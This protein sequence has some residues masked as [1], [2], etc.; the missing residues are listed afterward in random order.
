MNSFMNSTDFVYDGDGHLFDFVKCGSYTSR[1]KVIL[2]GI[3]FVRT[4][5]CTQ[6][7]LAIALYHPTFVKDG[8]RSQPHSLCTPMHSLLATINTVSVANRLA[9]HTDLPKET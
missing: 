9:V 3:S 5:T 6:N 8:L 1:P 7:Y 4:P 2:R